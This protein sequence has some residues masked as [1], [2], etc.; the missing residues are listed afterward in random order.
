MILGIDFKKEDVKKD[1]YK[2]IHVTVLDDNQWYTLH[3]IDQIMKN[4]D[5]C[6]VVPTRNSYSY[7]VGD[8]ATYSNLMYHL[9]NEFTE[10]SKANHTE[11]LYHNFIYEAGLMHGKILIKK[12][13]DEIIDNEIIKIWGY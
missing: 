9:R 13:M 7:K 4:H 10:Y 5:M 1:T 11:D 6:L 12:T 2:V 8:I 3:Y